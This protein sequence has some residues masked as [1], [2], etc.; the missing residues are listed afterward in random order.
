[1]EAAHMPFGGHSSHQV[2]CLHWK[3]G[4]CGF[5]AEADKRVLI[6][7]IQQKVV[8]KQKQFSSH[9][10]HTLSPTKTHAYLQPVV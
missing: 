1:M 4:I 3:S 7:Y 2:Y 6:C 10:T 8:K 5:E 9:H